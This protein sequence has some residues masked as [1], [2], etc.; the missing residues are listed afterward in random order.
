MKLNDLIPN[1]KMDM[2]TYA[3]GVYSSGDN[4]LENPVK[5]FK[6]KKVEAFVL[7]SNNPDIE[8]T[9]FAD[10][11]PASQK[12]YEDLKPLNFYFIIF[13][14]DNQMDEMIVAEDIFYTSDEASAYAKKQLKQMNNSF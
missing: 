7:E 10:A 12:L 6:L 13:V 14:V 8:D 3:L 9:V 2:K 11:T 5:S 4:L 1:L